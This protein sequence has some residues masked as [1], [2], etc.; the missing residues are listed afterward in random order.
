MNWLVISTVLSKLKDFSRSNKR[1]NIS[2]IVQARE[3][4]NIDTT[5]H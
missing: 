4:V 1:G 5:K 3:V 2:E